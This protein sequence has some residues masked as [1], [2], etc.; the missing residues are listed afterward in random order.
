MKIMIWKLVKQL[1]ASVQMQIS[2]EKKDIDRQIDLTMEKI[3]LLEDI[4]KDYSSLQNDYYSLKQNVN[5]VNVTAGNFSD[6]KKIKLHTGL[7]AVIL[8]LLFN[9]VAWN[10]QYYK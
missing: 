7:S 10:R 1:L 4:A 5:C 3:S 6:E 9:F 2:L 8:K